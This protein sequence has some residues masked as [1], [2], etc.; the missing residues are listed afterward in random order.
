[1]IDKNW[2]RRRFWDFRHGHNTYLV[3]ILS[4]TNFVVINYSLLISN[5]PF[6]T[7][8]FKNFLFFAVFFMLTYP[9]L[10]II[11][12]YREFRKKQLPTD[13]EIQTLT[14]PF[15]WRALPGKERDLLFPMQMLMAKLSLKFYAKEGILTEDEKQELNHYVKMLERL[16]QGDS[17]K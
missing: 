11:I 15:L 7:G 9:P 6:L 3:F 1:M 10:A 13:Q 14:N 4:L 8:I 16:L 2:I 12:G 5:I 17:L